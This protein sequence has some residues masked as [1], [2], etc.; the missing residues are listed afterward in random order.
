MCLGEDRESWE[1]SFS[2]IMNLMKQT[3]PSKLSLHLL[4]MGC[5]FPLTSQFHC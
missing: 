1:G 2:A 3:R 4:D 5:S